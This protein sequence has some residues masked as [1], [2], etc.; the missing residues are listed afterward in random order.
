M[1]IQVV[2]PC[3]LLLLFKAPIVLCGNQS[4]DK[5][6]TATEVQN[7]MTF[8]FIFRQYLI[9]VLCQDL[10]SFKPEPDVIKHLNADFPYETNSIKLLERSVFKVQ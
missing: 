4:K 2:H 6:N 7:T 1:Y 3:R 9:L 5:Y 8:N 10:F